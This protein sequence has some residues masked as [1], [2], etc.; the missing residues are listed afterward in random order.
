[1]PLA[2]PRSKLQ[3]SFFLL[4]EQRLLSCGFRKCPFPSKGGFL[5]IPGARG[6]R[7]SKAN[8]T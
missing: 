2:C 8:V 5:E 1:L 6:R 4:L 3:V 7:V